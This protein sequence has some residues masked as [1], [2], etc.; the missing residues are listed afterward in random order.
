VVSRNDT[1]NDMA[2]STSLTYYKLLNAFFLS[3][4]DLFFDV[5]KGGEIDKR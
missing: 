1:L 3:A 4:H 5:D 2:C